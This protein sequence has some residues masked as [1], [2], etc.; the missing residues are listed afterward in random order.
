[1]TKT[2]Q[3]SM[4]AAAI[5]RFGGV[6]EIKLQTLPIPEIESDEV[7]IRVEAAGGLL[8]RTALCP[9]PRFRLG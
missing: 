1:M 8:I 2:V 6:E 7:L 4:Q 5:D 3:K 9:S